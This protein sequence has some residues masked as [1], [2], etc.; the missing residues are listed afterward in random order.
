MIE[1]KFNLKFPIG[2]KV[3]AFVLNHSEIELTVVGYSISVNNIVVIRYECQPCNIE[4]QKYGNY[5]ILEKD[6]YV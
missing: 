4:L 3:K 2:D 6:L 1:V 5:T